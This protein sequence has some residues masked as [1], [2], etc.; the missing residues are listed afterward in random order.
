MSWWRLARAFRRLFAIGVIV[1]LY[2]FVFA[3]LVVVVGASFDG[4]TRGFLNFPPRDLSLG[5]FAAIDE[6]LWSTLRLSLTIGAISSFASMVLGTLAALALVRGRLPG[7]EM[8]AAL[9]RA[10]LQIPQVVTGIALLQFYYLLGERFGIEAVGSLWGLI[11]GHTFLGMPFVIGAVTA[12]L[13]RLNPRLEEAALSLGASRRSAFR[14][15]TLPG[16]A[17]GVYAG[18]LYAFIVSFGDVPVSIFLVSGDRT[19]FP[20][21]LFY[22]MEYD[23]KPSI[24]AISTLILAGSF[25]LLWIVQRGAGIDTF[26]RSGT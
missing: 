24:L 1:T 16:I 8:L 17:S 21:E 20:V 3:P 13:Q 5:A 18:G 23:F 6:R 25:V 9:F 26:T 2:T 15:V 22:A 11:V 14:R 7:R 19:T 12:S 10:P 4:S